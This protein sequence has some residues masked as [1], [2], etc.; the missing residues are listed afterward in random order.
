M[1]QLPLLRKYLSF[2]L[3]TDDFTSLNPDNNMAWDMDLC[4][5]LFE[6]V[7][8]PFYYFV[9]PEPQPQTRPFRFLDLP[10]DLQLLVYDHCDAP[11]LF[12]LMRTCSRS[13]GPAS[14]LFWSSKDHW[15]HFH[16]YGMFDFRN[17]DHIILDH[18]LEFAHHIKR[19]EF[20][21][22]RLEWRFCDDDKGTIVAK[23]Q[24]FWTKVGKVFP[25]VEDV[26]LVGYSLREPSM[27]SA[28]G[29]AVQFAPSHIT[30]LMALETVGPLGQRRQHYT[31][32]SVPEDLDAKWKVVD[33]DWTPTRV[34]LPP[35]KFPVSPLG[36]LMTFTRRDSALVLET[37]GLDWLR[38]ESYVRYAVDG[39]IHCPRLDCGATFTNRDEWEQHLGDTLNGWHGR[40]EY[41]GRKSNRG[42]M[43]EF[44][45]YKHT[46][47]VERATMEAR[48]QRIDQGHN[49]SRKL[50]RRV[51]YGWGPPGSEQ[52]RL[53]EEQFVA[54]LKEE[55]LWAPGNITGSIHDGMYG[56]LSMYFDRTHIYGHG[57]DCGGPDAEHICYDG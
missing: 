32:Y 40:F 1:A 30:V 57:H 26:V 14:K 41:N 6:Q 20:G 22:D 31:L 25:A 35:R 36:D 15:Y 12:H 39:K 50:Q 52:R 9:K 3:S 17:G 56:A 55:N 19:V 29:K 8:V 47:E 2:M 7:L 24:D 48:Q 45:P 33:E 16:R 43:Y 54:Q 53:F 27:Y 38:L 5:G 49:E 4:M 21:I 10:V 46:P 28:I 51:G 13:R 37:R 18:D 42:T 23:A 34:L 11:T 44:L